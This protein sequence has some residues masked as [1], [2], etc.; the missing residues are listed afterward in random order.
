MKEYSKTFCVYP[1]IELMINTSGTFDYCC[2]ANPSQ[3]KDKNNNQLKINK[4]SLKDVWNSDAMKDIRKNMIEGNKIKSCNLCYLQ[5]DSGRKSYRQLHNSEWEHLLGSKK[6]EQIVDKSIENNLEVDTPPVYLDLRMGNTCNLKCRMCN[7]FNSSLIT[8]EHFKL[9]D[10]SK[11]YANIFKKNFGSNPEWLNE[12]AY[13]DQFNDKK[14][15]KEIYEVLPTLEKLYLTGGEPTLIKNNIK[16]LEKLIELNKQNN[17][18]IFLNTNCT[19]SG[20]NFLEL[21][22]KFKEMDISPSIDGVGEVNNYIRGS[23]KWENIYQNC[24]NILSVNNKI[25]A[26][27]TPVLQIYNLNKIHEILNLAND[28]TYELFYNPWTKELTNTIG[29]DI[30]F[31]THPFMLDVRNLPLELRQ[32]AIQRLLDFKNEYV[33]EFSFMIR[34]TIEGTVGYLKQPQLKN[35]K[36]NLKDFIDYTEILDKERNQSFNDI[37]KELYTEIKKIAR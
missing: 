17:T 3:L 29:V 27:I 18:K 30:L 31:N 24:K 11:T 28:I 25:S 14:I 26:N 36:Q 8:K 1:W 23:K 21:L 16:V 20:K 9:F 34:N 13:R 4:D 32:N 22:S 12:Q 19:Y 35:Y 15:W 7:P 6:I 37:D 10:K 33:F 2:L 5:E